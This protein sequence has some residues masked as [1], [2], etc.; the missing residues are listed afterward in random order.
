MPNKVYAAPFIPFLISSLL[1]TS[2]A[3]SAS[4][5]VLFQMYPFELLFRINTPRTPPEQR[6]NVVRADRKYGARARARSYN[7]PI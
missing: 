6:F 5:V 1:V 4:R 7:A 3:L 2:V